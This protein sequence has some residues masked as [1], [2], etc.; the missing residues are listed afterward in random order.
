MISFRILSATKEGMLCYL[1]TRAEVHHKSRAS[2]NGELRDVNDI[3]ALMSQNTNATKWNLV[4]T[5]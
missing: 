2:L 3:T 5:D 1:K 4:L